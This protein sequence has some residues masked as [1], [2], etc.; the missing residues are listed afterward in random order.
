MPSGSPDPGPASTRP[1]PPPTSPTDVSSAVVNNVVTIAVLLLSP[2]VAHSL[3]LGD[4]RHDPRALAFLGLGTTAGYLAQALYQL[5]ALR[6][7]GV[8]LRWVW[9]LREPTV[10]RVAS[11]S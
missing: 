8:R 4:I 2:H 3:S 1:T 10:R 11:L 9:D 6:R 7:C 5:P